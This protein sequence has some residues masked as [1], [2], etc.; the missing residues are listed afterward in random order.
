MWLFVDWRLKDDSR[1]VKS[2]V[3]IE[4]GGFKNTLNQSYCKIL[5]GKT[6]QKICGQSAWYFVD[7]Y[8]EKVNQKFFV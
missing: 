1:N 6:S 2:A 5:K 3:K 7:R 4:A 8:S